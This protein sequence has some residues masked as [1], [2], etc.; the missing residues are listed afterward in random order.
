MEAVCPNSRRSRHVW[1]LNRRMVGARALFAVATVWPSGETAT[2]RTAS[3]CAGTRSRTSRVPSA[4]HTRAMRSAPP[5]AS[6][7]PF[8]EK[9][10]H[11]TPPGCAETSRAAHTGRPS[12]AS[13]ARVRVTAAAPAPPSAARSG[14]PGRHPVRSH[15]RIAPAVPSGPSR[16]PLTSVRPSGLKVTHSASTPC[17]SARVTAGASFGTSTSGLDNL[18]DPRQREVHCPGG[19]S[20]GC[21]PA[22]PTGGR[23][24]RPRRWRS[25]SRPG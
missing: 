10:R 16:P 22:A 2:A 1:V 14:S 15:H 21:R 17:A 18:H 25:R 9:A 13:A 6:T 20:P 24:G 7:L 23:C 12:G 4:A 3:A 5:E 19:R 11:S 8:W